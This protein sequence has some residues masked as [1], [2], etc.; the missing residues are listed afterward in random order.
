MRA[1][2]PFSPSS[3]SY[4]SLSYQYFRLL[5]KTPS[6]GRRGN[7]RKCKQEDTDDLAGFPHAR[8][9][10]RNGAASLDIQSTRGRRIHNKHI[11]FNNE[12]SRSEHLNTIPLYVGSAD[13]AAE[14]ANV[15]VCLWY[16]ES[17]SFYPDIIKQ[18]QSI[19]E[20]STV[21]GKGRNGTTFIFSTM[22]AF[23]PNE[24]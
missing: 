21:I 10:T 5:L 13:D 17:N 15:P 2:P 19:C 1:L 6:L 24:K 9:D 22:K 23:I 3:L 14:G 7:T 11:Q 12:D 8:P 18:L 20:D 4:S 16:I